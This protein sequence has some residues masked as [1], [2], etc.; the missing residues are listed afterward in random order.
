M[1]ARV[2][3]SVLRF[4]MRIKKVSF[5]D[6]A[7]ETFLFRWTIPG[8]RHRKSGCNAIRYIRAGG[9]IATRTISLVRMDGGDIRHIPVC[10]ATRAAAR[11][12]ARRRLI[13]NH[14]YT[15]NQYW[16]NKTMT[17]DIIII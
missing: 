8:A 7:K 1:G 9:D 5:A 3:L 16:N 11:P 12:A 6:L 14:S 2:L 4:E 13:A 15:H 10:R 17:C